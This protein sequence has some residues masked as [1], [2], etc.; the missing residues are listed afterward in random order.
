MW[1]GRSHETG[2]I[3]VKYLKEEEISVY[4]WDGALQAE[5]AVGA[6][7]LGWV[8]LVCRRRAEAGARWAGGGY[9]AALR[10]KRWIRRWTFS[11]VGEQWWTF[12]APCTSE[13]SAGQEILPTPFCVLRNGLLQRTTFL[14]MTDMVHGWLPCLPRTRPDT[15]PSI[16]ILCIIS[17]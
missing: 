10:E 14:H 6:K 9:R 13:K 17:D 15:D 1:K 8:C 12:P 3:W 5:G 4:L 2:G 7:A 16:P 11:Q